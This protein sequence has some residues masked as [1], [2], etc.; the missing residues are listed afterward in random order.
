MSRYLGVDLLFNLNQKRL[1]SGFGLIIAKSPMT[2]Y[3]SVFYPNNLPARAFHLT[4]EVTCRY[5]SSTVSAN[6][7]MEAYSVLT[8]T[9]TNY[10]TLLLR[11][12]E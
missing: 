7:C 1:K 4:T 2:V 8:Q 6:C 12:T 5:C 11:L 3:L 10:V 9:H